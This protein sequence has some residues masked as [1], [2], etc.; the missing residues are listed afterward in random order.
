MGKER[1][2]YSKP[3]TPEKNKSLSLLKN[4]DIWG[5]TVLECP[6]HRAEDL[7]SHSPTPDNHWLS[8]SLA[9]PQH[10][11]LTSASP[12]PWTQGTLRQNDSGTNRCKVSI[13][14]LDWYTRKPFF[15]N[16]TVP[17]LGSFLPYF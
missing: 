17:L 11:W 16:W 6:S 2:E 5:N 14:A 4:S 3:G 1:S 15:I 8:P 9:A 12:G 7:G 13:G 10:F